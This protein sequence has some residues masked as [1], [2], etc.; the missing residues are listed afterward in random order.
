MSPSNKLLI[1]DSIITPGTPSTFSQQE[2]E[3][4]LKNIDNKKPYEPLPWPQP[5]MSNGGTAGRGDGL[6]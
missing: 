5:L 1:F 6:M 2:Y 3:K 4:A